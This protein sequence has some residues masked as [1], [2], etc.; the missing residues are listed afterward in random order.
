M[1]NVYRFHFDSL[2]FISPQKKKSERSRWLYSH[3]QTHGDLTPSKSQLGPILY[4][5]STSSSAL[6][7]AGETEM[8]LT[9]GMEIKWAIEF[10]RS[11]SNRLALLHIHISH[12]HTFLQP[13]ED[14][15]LH[16]LTAQSQ[17]KPTKSFHISSH[18]QSL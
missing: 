8:R 9:S 4:I 1:D 17:P 11:S 5:L 18:F 16:H 14:H 6:K 15:T 3:S 10:I 13:V 2:P 7:V 12:T